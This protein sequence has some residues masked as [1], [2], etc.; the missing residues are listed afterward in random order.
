MT[1]IPLR[2][3]GY[4]YAICCDLPVDR[5]KPI[6]RCM[7]EVGQSTQTQ[8]ELF[9]PEAEGTQRL[10][11]TGR[12]PDVYAAHLRLMWEFNAG[13]EKPEVDPELSRMQSQIAELQAQLDSVRSSG[14][15]KPPGNR[16]GKGR[17]GRR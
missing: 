2:Y 13:E 12:L 4:D 15:N 6:R 8:I 5:C 11:I 16:G 10:H 14:P 7:D 9:G 3:L 1:D 17:N